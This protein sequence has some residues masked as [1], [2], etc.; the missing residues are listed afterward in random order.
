[1]AKAGDFKLVDMPLREKMVY[2]GYMQ[3]NKKYKSPYYQHEE[4]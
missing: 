1:M 2:E 3:M 4:T